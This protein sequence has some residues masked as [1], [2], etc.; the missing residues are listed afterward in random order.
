MNVTENLVRAIVGFPQFIFGWT[1]SLIAAVFSDSLLVAVAILS[2][3][4]GFATES[5]LLGFVTFFGLYV[6]QRIVG[7][8]ATAVGSLGGAIVAAARINSGSAD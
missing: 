4:V 5:V 6:L 8:V 2:V 7:T 3:L 1:V